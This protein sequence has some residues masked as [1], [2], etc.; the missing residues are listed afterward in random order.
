MWVGGLRLLR[1]KSS[2]GDA[3]GSWVSRTLS[4][5]AKCTYSEG[6]KTPVQAVFC[7]PRCEFSQLLKSA[8]SR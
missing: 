8:P 3:H 4:Y 2:T 7:F 6:L 1:V 5:S